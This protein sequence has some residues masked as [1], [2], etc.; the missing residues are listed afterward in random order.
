MGDK[1]ALTKIINKLSALSANNG[2]G[3]SRSG[4]VNPKI[5]PT[6]AVNVGVAALNIEK[7]NLQ[8]TLETLTKEL[9]NVNAEGQ[10]GDV[11]DKAKLA[12]E[13]AKTAVAPDEG[14]E[15]NI[16]PN[17]AETAQ[18]PLQDNILELGGSSDG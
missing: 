12:M 18:G 7:A 15:M 3:K 13:N 4:L 16:D 8:A 9:E 5:N 10:S 11:L 14:W 6:P 1:V 17:A 2:G